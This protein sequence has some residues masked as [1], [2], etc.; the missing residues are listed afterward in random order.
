MTPPSTDPRPEN[1]GPH[2]VP[3]HVSR[4]WDAAYTDTPAWEIGRAQEVFASAGRAGLLCGRLLDIGCGTGE[5]TLLTA[6]ADAQA[7]GIDVS[8]L[9]IEI[10]R[11]KAKDHGLPAEF[12]VADITGL[13]WAEPPFDT[14]VDS[15]TFHLFGGPA[16]AAYVA[17][18]HR[19]LRPGGTVY[20]LCAQAERA[21]GWGPPGLSRQ[22]LIASF[23][24]GW[25]IRGIEPARFDVAPPAPVA[26][27][28]AWFATIVRTA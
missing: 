23:S 17:A 22:D 10:A 18:V 6:R 8:V 24:D 3:A 19:V 15:G 26:G 9:A 5:T 7:W 4:M 1:G 21:G 25:R 12:R 11:A 13:E 2:Y 20:L 28:D 16:R 27:V 14:V